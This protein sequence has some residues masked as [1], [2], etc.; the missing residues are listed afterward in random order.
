[1]I[2]SYFKIAVKSLA[3]SR[4]NSIINIIGLSTG[5]ACALVIAFIVK[6]NLGFD[7]F[8]SH[9]GRTYR[10]VRV[11]EIEGNEE[12]R[13]GAS[14]PLFSALKSGIASLR[15]ITVMD[16]WGGAQIDV[17][18][19]DGNSESKFLEETGGVFTDNSF[20]RIFDFRHTN[21]R[22][23]E[24]NPETALKE[25]NTVVLSKTIAYKYFGNADP[26]G[27]VLRING[28]TLVTITGVVSD[29]PP[30]T[31]FPFDIFISYAT[32]ANLVG[33]NRMSNWNSIDDDNQ[34][35]LVLPEGTSPQ[36]MDKQIARV[37]E[38]NSPVM[39]KFRHYVLQPLAEVNRDNRFGNYT[40]KTTS[41]TTIWAL[42]LSG[43][44]LL[45]IACINFINLSIARSVSRSREIGIRKVVGGS[46]LQ[47]IFQF[48]LETFLLT[49]IAGILALL[50]DEL[51]KPVFQNLFDFHMSGYFM[52]HVFILEI[53][54]VIILLVT[55]L[56]GLYPALLLSGFAPVT[57]LKNNVYSK[58]SSG[59]RLSN[60]LIFTQFAITIILVSGTIIL[61]KQMQ[62]FNRLD[63]GFNKEAVINVPLPTNKP[64]LLNR[65]RDQWLKDPLIDEV[66]FSSTTPSG[67]FRNENSTDIARK[68]ASD[69][70]H[71][72]FECQFVDT[73]YINLY[74][75]QLIAGRNFTEADTGQS[76]ILNQTLVK[77]LGFNTPE[78]A[79]GSTVTMGKDLTVIGVV[80]DF[81]TG[82]L[83]ENIDKVGLL[84][85][86]KAFRTA[87][88]KLVA[89]EEKI[90]PEVIQKTIT[91]IGKTW[92]S[93]Y[94]EKVFDY[95]FLDKN[96]EAFY[97]QE[98]RFTKIFQ[99][100]SI[101][102]L[103]I[104]AF[105]LYGLISFIISKKMKEIALRKIM[106]ASV[107]NVL[108]L[109]SRNYLRLLFAAFAVAGPVAYLIMSRWLEK[110]AFRIHMQWWFFILPVILVLTGAVITVSG[111]LFKAVQLNPADTLRNE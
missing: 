41:V 96:I 62:F 16:Y 82:S 75:I 90:D 3:A 29:L 28:S 102:F 24:G 20:F 19:K 79:I 39:A 88:I 109:L 51:L 89:G 100:L 22:W 15:E 69:N 101:L 45:V 17:L 70:D 93:V 67:R 25:P 57:I 7:T 5:I 21:F 98:L 86:P 12:Y 27:R 76:I 74:R 60:L 103:M 47:L 44:F 77:K 73:S 84:I 61:Y 59:L 10:V 48:I 26:L 106:G 1:M 78:D 104:G 108:L 94:P 31:D 95:S 107:G 49:C 56:A 80:R 35:Y 33:Q 36:E 66:S 42:G 92:S 85:N 54:A 30:N 64:V 32:L 63:L 13:T 87:S 99:I 72:V 83:R 58:V 40:G 68:G 18:G 97:G 65:L 110:Y 9:A 2:K 38:S 52:T 81:H 91:S 50:Y 105:G 23:L 14:W 111:H 71:L 6:Y 8:H 37:H 4:M 46:R 43:I 53:L 55:L 11:S 34:V